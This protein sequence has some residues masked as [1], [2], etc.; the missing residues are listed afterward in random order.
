M[1]GKT[2]QPDTDV[3]TKWDYEN[4]QEEPPQMFNT[5]KKS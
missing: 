2:E 4:R 1:G 5:K 3:T